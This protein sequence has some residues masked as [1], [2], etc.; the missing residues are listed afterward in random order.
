[1]MPERWPSSTRGRASSRSEDQG[2]PITDRPPGPPTS[3][4]GSAGA[5]SGCAAKGEP[6]LSRIQAR[7]TSGTPD[8]AV[9]VA[10]AESGSLKASADALLAPMM[11]AIASS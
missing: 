2:A 3:A 4:G 6:S 8:K 1:M 5:S 7:T 10:R 11:R 9:S